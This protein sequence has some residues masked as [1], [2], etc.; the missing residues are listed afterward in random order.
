MGIKEKF[1]NSFKGYHKDAPK[2]LKSESKKLIAKKMGKRSRFSKAV[3][4]MVDR[5]KNWET[6]DTL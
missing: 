3:G 5:N 1:E 6:S 4:K 2:H